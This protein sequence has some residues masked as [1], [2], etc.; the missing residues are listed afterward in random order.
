[1]R[2]LPAALLLLPPCPLLLASV[3][4]AIVP[5]DAQW[6]INVDLNALRTSIIG[7]ELTRI[8][9]SMQEDIAKE[10]IRLNVEKVLSLAHSVT[11]FGTTFSDKPEMVD[12]TLVLQ[13]SP[14]LAKIADALAAQATV[15]DPTQV[16]ELKDLPFIAYSIANEVTVAFPPEAAVLASKSREKLLEAQG[17]LRGSGASLARAKSQLNTLLDQQ[18][19]HFLTVAS[20]VPTS[21]GLFDGDGPQSRILQMAHSGA[22]FL[23][24]EGPMTIARIQLAA[25][26]DD[27]AD[28]LDR[29][30][31][32]LAAMISLAE[33]DDAQLAEFLRSVNVQRKGSVVTVNLAYPSTRLV[34]MLRALHD[35]KRSEDREEEERRG[36]V[37][38][39]ISSRD[40]P[41]V[42][43]TVIGE[44]VADK[45]LGSDRAAAGNLVT[46]RLE[47]VRLVPGAAIFLNGRR[48]E[49]ENA[50]FDYLEIAPAAGAGATVRHEAEDM[51]LSNYNIERAP[52]A[53]S[54]ELIIIDAATGNAR[55]KFQGTEGM[56]NLT[57]AYVDETDGECTLSLSIQDP[58]PLPAVEATPQK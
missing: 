37:Q 2:L 49:G 24:E 29:I 5:A 50:R 57:I 43:G 44:W 20:M 25:S 13:G 47:N 11:A 27:M 36:G 23:G 41:K 58:Q 56:Y 35:E 14:E 32:G 21:P 51:R 18:A 26:S 45:D 52:F 31:Q 7:Q 15:S 30:L 19:N 38:V 16:K 6:V 48:H 4:R 34:E 22:I 8:A 9:G 39:S 12:G 55:L 40:H 3:D 53:S 54:G 1:M 17:L 28:R 42:S 33:S 10:G 46:H